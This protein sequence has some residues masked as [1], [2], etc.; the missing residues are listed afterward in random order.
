MRYAVRSRPGGSMPFGFAV[1]ACSDTFMSSTM[2]PEGSPLA[3]GPSW[4]SWSRRGD[5][6][7]RRRAG[8]D[9]GPWYGV[10]DV[11]G[12]VNGTPITPCRASGREGRSHSTRPRAWTCQRRARPRQQEDP[13]DRREDRPASRDAPPAA[14]HCPVP[15]QWQLSHR[16]PRVEWGE[17]AMSDVAFACRL[18]VFDVSERQRYQGLR[19][20]MKA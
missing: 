14:R 17:S 16:G 8:L 6:L 18:D 9:P 15:M 20:T 2:K 5:G 10:D 12:G 13:R 1:S 19:A 7:L 3:R 11:S 4:R